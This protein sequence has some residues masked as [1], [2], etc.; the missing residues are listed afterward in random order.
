[1]EGRKR[2]R[3][4]QEGGTPLL[5]LPDCGQSG[6]S[7]PDAFLSELGAE[8]PV[9]RPDWPE[10]EQYGEGGC[11]TLA[12][13]TVLRED[14]RGLGVR[15]AHVLGVGLGALVALELALGRGR[16]VER[17]VLVGSYAGKQTA[18]ASPP[19][20]IEA[21]WRALGAPVTE[22]ATALRSLLRRQDEAGDGAIGLTAPG[23]PLRSHWGAKESFEAYDRLPRI[24]G[25]T[26]V[27]HGESDV[28]V[29]AENG[30]TL[31]SRISG[32]KFALLP[33]AGHLALHDSPLR[34]AWLVREFLTG[35][36]E[37]RAGSAGET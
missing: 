27:L 11:T 37:G 23:A 1:M 18:V 8:I 9:L 33:G 31:A 16:V 28:L 7:W 22:Q 34:A 25:A 19:W 32:A 26:L 3:V 2:A 21:L 4:H 5:L 20:V 36:A 29:L 15:R 12:L 35:P 13:A 6:A 10:L 17:L 24:D 30:R 14:L